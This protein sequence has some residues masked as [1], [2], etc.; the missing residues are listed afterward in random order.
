MTGGVKV[1]NVGDPLASAD[2]NLYLM[3]QAN[4]RFATTAAR[5]AQMPTPEDG[6]TCYSADYGEQYVR[7]GGVW[8]SQVPRFYSI[9]TT[10]TR[11]S[12]IGLTNYVGSGSTPI[13]IPLEPNSLYT[14]D[15][16]IEYEASTAGDC[17][18]YF[19]YSGSVGSRNRLMFQ[20]L[21]GGA[22]ANTDTWL[23]SQN[24]V[25]YGTNIWAGGIGVSNLVP[26]IGNAYL[27]TVLG[28]NIGMQFAQWT[29]DTG[30][31]TISTAQFRVL[32]I[33]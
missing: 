1:W 31:T 8:Q 14:V 5:D 17:R 21:R 3:S 23:D 29:S 4:P 26:L 24:F 15:I 20:I 6:Q 10:Q 12:N 19:P 22:A 11:T 16:Q 9:A 18:L 28:G 27:S 2:L 33:G 30:A 7:R 13:S 25:N 32:K